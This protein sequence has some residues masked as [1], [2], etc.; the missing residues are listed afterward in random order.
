[1]R[2][3]FLFLLALTTFSCSPD[4]PKEV[5]VAMRE[6]PEELDY[7]LHV[8][9]ILSDKCFACHG[10]DMAKQKAGLRLDLS[11]AAYGE[12]PE[13]EGNYAIDPGD[14]EDSQVFHRI[15]SEDP[16]YIM[17]TPQ[18]HLTLT[19]YEKAVLI[20]WIDDGAEYKPHWAFVKP[21]KEELPEVEN[22]TQ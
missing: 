1:M 22:E 17:P 14:L 20:K 12:L 13:N 8:K 16:D 7:N 4:L 19:A 11:E 15:L 6:L 10:P 3:L 21:E 9:P 18:S 5:R 2:I